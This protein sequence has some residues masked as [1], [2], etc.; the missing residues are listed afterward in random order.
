MF[1]LKKIEIIPFR[2]L[3]KALKHITE[4]KLLFIVKKF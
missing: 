4:Q 2:A 3:L 1:K